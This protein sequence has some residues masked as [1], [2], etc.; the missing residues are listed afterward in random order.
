MKILQYIWNTLPYCIQNI[1]KYFIPCNIPLNNRRFASIGWILFKKTTIW[2]W[3]HFVNWRKRETLPENINIWNYTN[4]NWNHYFAVWPENNIYIWN[5]CSIAYGASF[6]TTSSHDYKALTITPSVLPIKNKPMIWNDIIIGHDVRIWKDAIILK[7]VT[8]WTWAVIWAWSIVT[9]DV[10]PYAIV[11]WN[12]A[13]IIKYRFSKDVIDKLLK[14]E[15]RNWPL[16][17]VSDN[18]NLEFLN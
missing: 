11:G 17:K 16:E 4:M 10:P 8:I 5:F 18:Y 3:C 14:S 9:K 7:W 2:K 6:I 1:I 12:P 13:K 15:R